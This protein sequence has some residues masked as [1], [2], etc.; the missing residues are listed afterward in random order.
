MEMKSLVKYYLSNTSN[1]TTFS[2]TEKYLKLTAST[3]EKFSG[4]FE[5]VYLVFFLKRFSF[6]VK[7]Q[8]KSPRK[9]YAIDTGLCNT[10][11]FRFSE[12][13]GKLVENI[14]FLELQRRQAQQPQI[15]LYYWKDIHHCEVDF[16]VKK[17]QKISELIQV[18]WNVSNLK[19]KNREIRSLV[20]AMDELGNEEATI[21]TE[22]HEGFE[23]VK[24]KKITYVPLWRWL[25]G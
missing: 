21:I 10:I 22:E 6:T 13:I 15:E 1:L 2:S 8:E 18:C 11:G 23:D 9:V 25:L 20:R 3:V 4:Y 17:G 7:E 12:N 14:V 16:V 19:T 24:G 5:D